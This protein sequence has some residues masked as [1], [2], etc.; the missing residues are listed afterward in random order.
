MNLEPLIQSKV[1]QKNKYHILTH[2][3]EI[4][5]NG[6]DEPILRAGIETQMWRMDLWSQWRKER[7]ERPERVALKYINYC[8]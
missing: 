3:Y 6:T 7:V 2:M 1:G 4:Q 5:K 8:L